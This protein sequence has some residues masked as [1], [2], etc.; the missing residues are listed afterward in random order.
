LGS[1]RQIWE[2]AANSWKIVEMFQIYV[3]LS[4]DRT[5]ASVQQPSMGGPQKMSADELSE[6]IRHLTRL[7]A[8]MSPAR[9]HDPTPKIRT[10]GAP[11]P[12]PPAS[13][14]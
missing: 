6:L 5:Q 12:E 1:F 9:E 2:Q 4:E 13:E 11:D 7:R 10:V 14:P 8:D 3:E